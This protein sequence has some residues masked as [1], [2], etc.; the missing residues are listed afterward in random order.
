MTAPA[1]VPGLDYPGDYVARKPSACKAMR[2]SDYT[3]AGAII[4]WAASHAVPIRTNG[5]ALE[6]CR[7]GGSELVFRGDWVVGWPAAPDRDARFERVTAP[8]FAGNFHP[9]P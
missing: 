3:S 6:I 5:D 7:R 8:T 2:F 1:G 4:A 9:A